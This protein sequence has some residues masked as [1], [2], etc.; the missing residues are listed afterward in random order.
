MSFGFSHSSSVPPPPFHSYNLMDYQYPQYPTNSSQHHYSSSLASNTSSSPASMAFHSAPRSDYAYASASPLPSRRYAPLENSTISPLAQANNANTLSDG[1]NSGR[2]SHGSN[3]SPSSPSGLYATTTGPRSRRF[4]PI[5]VPTP[6]AST[7]AASKSPN[8]STS[9]DDWDEEESAE[10]VDP[11]LREAVR[12]ERIVS[13]QKRRDELKHGFTRLKSTLPQTD[14]RLRQAE[15]LNFAVK[16]IRQLEAKLTNAAP[17]ERVRQLEA[18][19]E[20]ATEHVRQLEAELETAHNELN[21]Y[22]RHYEAQAW[23]RYDAGLVPGS[24]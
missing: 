3:P 22:K 4:D 20:T 10:S 16:H 1:R 6:R 19:L 14:Q 7:S 15:L 11:T 21:A 8:S 5:S 17:A 9:N 18:E 24:F 23:P 12:R 2:R 13:D